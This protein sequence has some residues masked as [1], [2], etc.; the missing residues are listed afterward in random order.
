M[1]GSAGVNDANLVAKYLDPTVSSL[2]SKD[3]T[4]FVETATGINN[5]TDAQAWLIF[6][7]QDKSVNPLDNKLEHA[8]LQSVFFNELK[9]AGIE[10]N[11]INTSGYGN[12]AR[13]YDVIANAFP[14]NNYKGVI[15]LSGS[16]IKTER[17]G[18]LSLLAPGGKVIVGLAK[19]D[20]SLLNS[21][22]DPSTPYNDSASILGVFTVKGGN[23]NIYSNDSVEVAQSRVFTILGG[24]VLIWS[25]S[26]NIDA[27]KGAKTATASPPPLV[28]TDSNGKTVIDLFG[29]VTGSG[30]GTLQ[31]LADAPLGNVYLIA[32]TGTVDAGDAGVRS[33]G[34]L[35]VAAQAV[36]N[37]ANMQAGGTSS[38]V[39]VTSSTSVTFNAPVSAESSNSAKQGEKLSDAA[40]KSA[41]NKS[42]AMPSLITVEVIALG[43][44]SSSMSEQN[45][46]EKKKVKK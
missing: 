1:A 21:K 15:D 38:G 13:G 20:I 3:L 27:G 10:H 26:G 34:N 31:T 2:Y 44:D 14:L 35:V 17:G 30:I 19:T 16:Q 29:V 39:P 5:L 4:R 12:Y 41:N 25:T 6:Q 46:D 37:G 42:N 45:S 43:D 18:D 11:T 24:D 22:D 36:A 8:F 23:I 28:R 33:S 32:P 7:N 40:S 9:Q